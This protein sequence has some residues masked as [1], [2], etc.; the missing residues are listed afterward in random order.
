MSFAD[1]LDALTRSASALK[2]AG[3]P[4]SKAIEDATKVIAEALL[5]SDLSPAQ[6]K[7]MEGMGGASVRKT[8]EHMLRSKLGRDLS[9]LAADMEG[10]SEQMAMLDD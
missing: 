6:R 2:Q 7:K 8:I 10:L 9:L 5:P 4:V 3:D 1:D